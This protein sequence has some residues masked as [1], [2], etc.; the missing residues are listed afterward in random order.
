M[1][2]VLRRAAY[3]IGYN[4]SVFLVAVPVSG[5]GHNIILYKIVKR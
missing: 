5:N 2:G 4:A 1:A 3:G